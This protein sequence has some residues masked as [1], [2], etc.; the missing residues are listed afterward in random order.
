MFSCHHQKLLS[1]V[2]S[3]A[4]WKAK[5][6][7]FFSPPFHDDHG[8]VKKWR[9]MVI[10]PLTQK[11]SFAR[12]N[13][14]FFYFACETFNGT[15]PSI[16]RHSENSEVFFSISFID[17]FFLVTDFFFF[18]LQADRDQKETKRE[19]M[20]GDRISFCPTTGRPLNMYYK[21]VHYVRM[22]IYKRNLEIQIFGWWS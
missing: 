5:G 17:L 20:N 3:T 4:R 7:I 13:G 6:S 9:K 16:P 11:P 12:P 10:A 19:K 15:H 2:R 8:V 18:F 1:Y 21:Q 22:C 14:N